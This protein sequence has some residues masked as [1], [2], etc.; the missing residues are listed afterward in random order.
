MLHAR[1]CRTS[2][3]S[4]AHRTASTGGRSLDG[5]CPRRRGRRQTRNRARRATHAPSHVSNMNRVKGRSHSL[6][7][8]RTVTGRHSPGVLSPIPTKI[9][10][11]AIDPPRGNENADSPHSRRWAFHCF[12]NGRF[13]R[14]CGAER[15]DEVLAEMIL[16]VT[17]VE[18]HA[19]YETVRAGDPAFRRDDGSASFEAMGRCASATSGARRPSARTTRARSAAWGTSVEDGWRESSRRQSDEHVTGRSFRRND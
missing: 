8:D 13:E 3:A 6:W 17:T 5:A 16:A 10:R 11:V 1:S 14:E 2:L 4:R 12:L 18:F 19:A 15:P 9:L 7:A